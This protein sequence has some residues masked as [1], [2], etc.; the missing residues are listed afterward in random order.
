MT[1]DNAGSLFSFRMADAVTSTASFLFMA[2]HTSRSCQAY[3]GTNVSRSR[4][5]QHMVKT[6]TR[7]NFSRKNCGVVAKAV[8]PVH[9]ARML[10]QRQRMAIHKPA[11]SQDAFPFPLLPPPLHIHYCHSFIPISLF[12]FH[13][14]TTSIFPGHHSHF[15]CLHTSFI[16]YSVHFL[17]LHI[18]LNILVSAILNCFFFCPFLLAM[19]RTHTPLPV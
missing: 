15:H 3:N 1:C 2:A 14:C 4:G 18:H 11:L 19:S 7:T 12:S 17:T 13:A 5:T 6:V 8:C 16:L 9:T 10:A